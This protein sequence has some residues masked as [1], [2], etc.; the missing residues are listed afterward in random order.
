MEPGRIA[1]LVAVAGFV[2]YLLSRLL[3]GRGPR[4]EPVSEGQQRRA[5][6]REQRLISKIERFPA[7]SRQRIHA[8]VGDML[9]DAANAD[10]S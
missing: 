3:I 10:D 1:L 4:R 8:A 2:V 9:Q 6:R 5:Q 7:S